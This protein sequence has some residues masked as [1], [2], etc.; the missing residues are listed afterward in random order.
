[1]FVDSQTAHLIH[2]SILASTTQLALL[3]GWSY[4]TF[5]A[6]TDFPPEVGRFVSIYGRH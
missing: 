4:S 5:A 6:I 2:A 3:V 1:M